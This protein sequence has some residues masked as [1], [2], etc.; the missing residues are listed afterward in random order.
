M[1]E[2]P[3]HKMVRL[4]EKL[5]LKCNVESHPEAAV[6][7]EFNGTNIYTYPTLR[8]EP[9][10]PENY[11]TY[12]CTA[13]LKHFPQVSSSMKIVPPGVPIISSLSPQYSQ[14]GQ[15]GT[16]QCLV[17]FEPKADVTISKH[18]FESLSG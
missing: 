2:L 12:K 7:W 3:S 6:T 10:R 15:K 18:N 16:I 1:E 13:S 11:G 17:D 14:Y 9:F 5:V 4:N 8:I